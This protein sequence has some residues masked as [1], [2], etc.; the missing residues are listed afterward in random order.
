MTKKYLFG[1][2]FLCGL[3]GG[4]HAD[5]VSISIDAGLLEQANGTSVVQTGALLQLIASPSATF[6]APSA[7]SYVGGDN[8]VVS[9][10]SMNTGGGTGETTNNTGT[11]TLTTT[12]FAGEAL[13]LRFYPSLLTATAPASG[14]GAGTNYGQIRSDTIEFSTTDDPNETKWVV[15]AAGT[16]NAS[17]DYITKKDPSGGTFPDGMNGTSDGVT[18]TTFATLTVVPE[19]STYMSGL[20]GCLTVVGVWTRSRCR[21]VV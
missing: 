16:T 13:L 11:L 4:L 18:I 1:L 10:F 9:T 15:P 5:T 19:P 14:P 20:L 6:T 3:A 2:V 7:G 17:L 21:A 12:L 8:F